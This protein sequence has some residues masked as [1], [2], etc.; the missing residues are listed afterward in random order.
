MFNLRSTEYVP[1]F[2][3]CKKRR[4]AA[5]NGL[6]LLRNDEG[7]LWIAEYIP[8]HQSP[9]TNENGRLAHR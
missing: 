2:Q 7:R 3:A 1:T 6:I 5:F 4:S 9:L 8:W